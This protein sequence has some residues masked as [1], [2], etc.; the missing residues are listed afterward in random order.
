MF[1]TG[2][3]VRGWLLIEVRGAW[4]EDA[5]HSSAFG[6]TSRVT[7]RT[8]SS[9]ARSVPCASARILTGRCARRA[10]LRLRRPAPRQRSGA[11]LASRC[12]A[13]WPTSQPLPRGS[14]RPTPGTGGSTS[15][16]ADPRVHQRSPRPMLRNLGRPLVRALLTRRGPTGVGVLAHRRRPVRR[17]HRGAPRQPLLRSRRPG[18]GLRR[19]SALST[20][21]EST[22]H[23][24][25]GAP[26]SRSPSRRSNTSSGVSSEIDAVDGVIIDRKPR[27]LVPRPA[28][29]TR[30]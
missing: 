22:S 20:R 1:A 10:A 21:G 16:T 15:T 7:G 8:N 26:R 28:R 25:G 3:Q 23:C 12:R 17:Q 11:P 27:R 18:V 29:R 24:S 9:G 6:D 30:W 5:I 2:S 4:G 19:C 14:G 13:R